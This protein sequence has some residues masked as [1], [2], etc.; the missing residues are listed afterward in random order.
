M[1]DPKLFRNICL[2][3]A[4]VV[5]C[6]FDHNALAA[7]AVV[8]GVVAWFL[9]DLGRLV[10]ERWER[11]AIDALWQRAMAANDVAHQAVSRLPRFPPENIA[12]SRLTQAAFDELRCADE[13]LKRVPTLG[14]KRVR[15]YAGRAI[16]VAKDAKWLA[17]AALA[18]YE[19]KDAAKEP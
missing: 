8:G 10:W 6:G 13:T 11:V 14:L 12:I 4:V 1:T 15:Y 18:E 7:R 3:G 2:L 5:A 16:E 9:F 19:M 17:D